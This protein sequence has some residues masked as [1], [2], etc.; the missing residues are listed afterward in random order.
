MRSPAEAGTVVLSTP[1]ADGLE[2]E[3]SGAR[4]VLRHNLGVRDLDNDLAGR[5]AAEMTAS[6]LTDNGLFE[7]LFAGVVTS[8]VDDAALAWSA[9]YRNTLDRLTAEPASRGSIAEFAP[10]Y[11]RARSLVRGS[12]VLD[13]ASC[14]GFLPLLLVGDGLDVIASDLSHPSMR[15]LS[16]MDGRVRCCC[17]AAESLPF[18]DG[19]V[20]TVLAVHLLEH[21]DLPT[22]SRVL[23]E[24][25]RV[26]RRRVVVAVPYEDEP[27]AAYGHVRTL[28]HGAL[29]ALGSGSGLRFEVIDSDGGWLILDHAKRR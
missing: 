10:I 19:A 2:L 13:L 21:V 6:G 8:T 15:L 24:A 9:F 7:R 5:L 25:I 22:A 27:D 1:G 28:D 16:A 11:R 20:D 14:F 17:C 26:A 29:E 12:R 3:V 18:T 23:S 4:I